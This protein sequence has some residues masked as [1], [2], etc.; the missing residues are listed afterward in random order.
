MVKPYQGK[1]EI[2]LSK[3]LAHGIEYSNGD[4]VG[5]LETDILATYFL[6]NMGAHQI[7][8]Y[9]DIRDNYSTLCQSVLN[10][11]FLTVAIL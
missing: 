5:S 1:S 10:T 4:L 3:L 7:R 9:D 8:N 6:R 11:F 2:G